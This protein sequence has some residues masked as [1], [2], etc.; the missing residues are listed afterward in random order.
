MLVSIVFPIGEKALHAI[1]HFN[2][3]HCALKVKHYCKAEHECYLCAYM[4][5]SES[6]LLSALDS[7]T[8]FHHF[9]IIIFSIIAC[10]LFVSKK[11]IFTTRGPPLFELN[12]RFF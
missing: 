9:I 2:E 4:F 6:N 5:A 3:N 11:F 7:N 10:H 1:E 8:L 12:S